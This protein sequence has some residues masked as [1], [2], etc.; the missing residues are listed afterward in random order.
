[1]S[2]KLPEL[3]LFDDEADT[4]DLVVDRLA[5]DFDVTFC[6]TE[7]KIR[8][9]LQPERFCVIVCDVNIQFSN[10]TGY[11]IIDEIRTEYQIR[12]VPVVITIDLAFNSSPLRVRTPLTEPLSNNNSSAS[13]QIRLRFSCV[14][15]VWRIV[16]L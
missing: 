13:S 6:T 2:K 10:K 5:E 1:M 7:D 15:R 8:D 3:L 4:G 9:E 12:K 11:Q 14:S 16:F